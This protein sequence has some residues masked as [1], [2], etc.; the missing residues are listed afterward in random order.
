MRL[1]FVT[2]FLPYPPNDGGRIGYF[3]PIKY[4][5]RRHEIVLVSFAEANDADNIRALGKY[6]TEVR[7]LVA[8]KG[9]RYSRLV[10]GLFT[11]PPGSAGTYFDP[12]LGELIRASIRDFDIDVVEL[13]HLNTAAY[14]PYAAGAPVILREHNVE[15]KVWE[16]HGQH[17]RSIMERMFVRLCTPRIRHYE[18]RMAERFARCITVSKAD[19]RYLR[20]IAPGA[21]V[22]TIPSG[23]DT[24]Y[25]APLTN[26]AEEPCTMV[27]TGSFEWKPKQHNLRVLATEIFPRIKAKLPEAK[28]YIVG[29]GVPETLRREV[30]ANGAVV[31]G[32]VPDVRPYVHSATLVLNYLESGGGIA[33]KVLEAMAMRKPVLSNALGCEGIDVSAG[34]DAVIADGVQEFADSAVLLLGNRSLRDD[35]AN[36]GYEMVK[37]KYA[38][39]QLA[40]VF[41]QC[42]QSVLEE[43]VTI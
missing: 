32:P 9:N 23:V 28:L 12:R 22:L 43:A 8:P 7:T 39:S 17:A 5:S 36:S 42:Y 41:E 3:N 20:K 29:K 34:K 18:A 1:L 13:Q 10:K 26:I 21:K 24:E 14:L 19:E 16:R 31:T 25:F 40:G 6:C 15:Y 38:W 11:D 4:L 2:H 35:L 37:R 30:E 33:L 27:L